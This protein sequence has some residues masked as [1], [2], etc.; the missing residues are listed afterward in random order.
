MKTEQ[1][2]TAQWVGTGHFRGVAGEAIVMGRL[3]SNSALPFVVFYVTAEGGEGTKGVAHFD[4]GL[5]LAAAIAMRGIAAL[6]EVA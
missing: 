3:G 4:A 1:P 5:E 2:A 6:N